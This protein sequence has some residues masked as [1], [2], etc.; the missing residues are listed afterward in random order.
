MDKK[1][2][3]KNE[4]KEKNFLNDPDYQKAKNSVFMKSGEPEKKR[5]LKDMILIKE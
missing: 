1:Q 4:E 5:S 3:E 2:E